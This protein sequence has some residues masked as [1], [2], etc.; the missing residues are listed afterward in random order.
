MVSREQY[1]KQMLGR[2]K[3]IDLDADQP[4]L[5][6]PLNRRFRSY[7][8]LKGAHAKFDRWL[9]ENEFLDLTAA[10]AT[11]DWDSAPRIRMS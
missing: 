6:L 1:V 3:L 7:V 5:D 9:G 11:V 8:G 2:T 10:A 4:V